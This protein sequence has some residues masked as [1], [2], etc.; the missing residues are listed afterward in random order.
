MY[1]GIMV[2]FFIFEIIIKHSI[3]IT[4]VRQYQ[5]QLWAYWPFATLFHWADF[6]ISPLQP[7]RVPCMHWLCL[8]SPT[9]THVSLPRLPGHIISPIISFMSFFPHNKT[10][11]VVSGVRIFLIMESSI[12]DTALVVFVRGK[13]TYIVI[14]EELRDQLGWY[15]ADLSAK[16]K[17][18]K[19]VDHNI[20]KKMFRAPK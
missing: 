11:T 12:Y 18:G 19:D 2:G 4:M 14:V 7:F 15:F 13:F 6:D 17:F 8:H 9:W 3:S 5:Q 16:M 10:T 1:F 20:L